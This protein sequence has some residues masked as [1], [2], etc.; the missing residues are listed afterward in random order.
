VGDLKDESWEGLDGLH[1]LYVRALDEIDQ[2][3][4]DLRSM[5]DYAL[6]LKHS[7]SE[8]MSRIPLEA[9]ARVENF[10]LPHNQNHSPALLGTSLTESEWARWFHADVIQIDGNTVEIR[11][12][13]PLRECAYELCTICVRFAAR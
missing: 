8:L 10:D 4:T 5:E 12:L 9:C 3:K 1:A 11:P 2:L 7:E 13:R 6:G